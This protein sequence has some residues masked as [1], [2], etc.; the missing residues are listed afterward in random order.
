MR[1]LLSILLINPILVAG[2]V[3]K[4]ATENELSMRDFYRQALPTGKHP[5]REEILKTNVPKVI[6]FIK[7][8]PNK[9]VVRHGLFGLFHAALDQGFCYDRLSG[10]QKIAPRRK[11]HRAQIIALLTDFGVLPYLPFD[12][13]YIKEC[14]AAQNDFDVEQQRVLAQLRIDALGNTVA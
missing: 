4:K 10:A 14:F 12:K 9:V 1:L 8:N 7:Q 6:D 3:A 2:P 13:P 5:L 11:P